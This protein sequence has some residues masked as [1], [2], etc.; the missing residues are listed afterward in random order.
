[1]KSR[2]DFGKTVAE[3]QNLKSR[4]SS[5]SPA[6]KDASS[7]RTRGKPSQNAFSD[8]DQESFSEDTARNNSTFSES[9]FRNNKTQ[10]EQDAEEHFK[11]LEDAKLLT[12]DIQQRFVDTNKEI[13][14]QIEERQE[15]MRR[16]DEIE[17]G[18]SE[19]VGQFREVI[20]QK[21]QEIVQLNLQVT[22]SNYLFYIFR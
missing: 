2:I 1:M 21:D 5:L 19:V 17:Q 20:H 11:A 12:K 10:A 7:Q 18:Y 16:K 22:H 15:E 9:S 14:F 13:Q 3:L 8:E 6:P 4:I